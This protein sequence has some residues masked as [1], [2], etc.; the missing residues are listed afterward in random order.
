M[1]K[2]VMRPVILASAAFLLNACGSTGP[3]AP[4]ITKVQKGMSVQQV[5]TLLGRSVNVHRQFGHECRIYEATTE[6]RLEEKAHYVVFR[7]GSVVDVG[8][9]SRDADCFRSLYD[10]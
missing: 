9:G 3:T 4:S 6:D 5:E 2:G 10:R 8:E 7:N 1:A